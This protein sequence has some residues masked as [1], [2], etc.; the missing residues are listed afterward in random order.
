MS[1]FAK[2]VGNMEL[3]PYSFYLLFKIVFFSKKKFVQF[4]FRGFD[5]VLSDYLQKFIPWIHYAWYAISILAFA[6][7]MHFNYNDVGVTKAIA[8]LWKV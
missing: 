8:M 5:H 1:E 3:Y 4:I 7:L 6:G 2:M